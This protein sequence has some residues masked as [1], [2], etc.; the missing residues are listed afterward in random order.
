[1]P[2]VRSIGRWTMTALVINGIIG[3]GIFALPGE[4]N[5]L[6]GRESP[7]AVIC[8]AVAM[9][10]VIACVTEVASQFSEPGGAYLYTRIAF[11]RFVGMQIG[12]FFLLAVVGG[13]A[14][15]ANLFVN[16]LTPLLPWT[17]NTWARGAIMAL[18]IGIPTTANYF[19]VRSG[20]NL[21]TVITLAKLS[22]LALIIL[23][24]LAHFA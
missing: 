4:L 24:G 3:G 14:V 18:L 12:W 22:P 15:A 23:F 2:L 20:A 13:V 21:S 16:C 9:A 17:L 1:M 8:A 6:L 10:I 11:G 19:G 5:R 7:F